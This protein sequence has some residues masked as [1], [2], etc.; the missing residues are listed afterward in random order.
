MNI[1]IRHLSKS[2]YLHGL[3]IPVLRDISLFIETGDL[4]S[5]TGPSGVGK[6]TFL[7]V[8]GALDVPSAGSIL[9]DSRNIQALSDA[10]VAAF[11][12]TH[13]GH[14]FQFHH[15]IS[16]FT[17]A[18]NV[19]MPL[20][21]RRV[22]FH[23]ALKKA[24]AML[25]FVGL[26]HRVD[27]KPGELSGGEQ[28]RVALARALTHEPT[29]LLA[30][31]PTGNLDEKTGQDIIDLILHYNQIRGA[32]VLLVTHNLRISSLFK[33]KLILDERGLV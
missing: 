7:H 9:Y 3:E 22:S 4:I 24:K 19:M 30:D 33:K 1:D 13:I 17:A 10:Q 18:E 12:N 31:E 6:S 16:E 14:V 28:Q 20:L 8:I 29:L 26:S 27:H 25:S 11:R 32:T 15:L 21:I 23:E 2:Y 5:L